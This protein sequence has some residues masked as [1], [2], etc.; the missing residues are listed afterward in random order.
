MKTTIKLG[1]VGLAL[2]ASLSAN[3]ELMQTDLATEGDG[4]VTFD[5][6]TG[7]EWLKLTETYSRD[8][9]L[10]SDRAF[11]Q[12][13]DQIKE[14]MAEGGD[15]D[16]FRFA[17]LDEVADMFNTLFVE[18]NPLTFETKV[19]TNGNE[20]EFWRHQAGS[21]RVDT[22]PLTTLINIFGQVDHI[23]ATNYK[24]IY[25][26]GYV[27]TEE[28]NIYQYGSFLHNYTHSYTAPDYVDVF[29]G[30][31]VGRNDSAL[32]YNPYFLVSDGGATYSSINDPI[33]KD[34]QASIVSTPLAAGA[35]FLGLMGFARRRQK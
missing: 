6:S 30:K 32:V 17:T 34:A 5:S 24:Q 4:K 31:E 7:L 18:M 15:L 25:S 1:L 13:A 11:Y 35:A 28:G 20:Y 14:R 16:G 19:D 3:A 8:G 22:T 26:M 23:S 27:Y 12:S 29:M 9:Y 10:Q 21:N 2:T 33:V